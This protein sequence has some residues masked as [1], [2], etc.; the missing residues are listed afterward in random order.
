MAIESGA[1]SAM[2]A[3]TINSLFCT[4]P[5]KPAASANGT[6]SPSDMPITTS[7]ESLSPACAFHM[8]MTMC[9]H[10]WFWIE[11]FIQCDKTKTKMTKEAKNPGK[12]NRKS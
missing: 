1:I 5:L 9:I 3:M 8:R 10:F 6:V 7:L 11:I 2:P 4:A 12:T